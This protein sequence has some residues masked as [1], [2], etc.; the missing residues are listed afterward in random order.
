MFSKS[1]R[2]K[3]IEARALLD[4][5]NTNRTDTSDLCVWGIRF[6]QR[7]TGLLTSLGRAGQR[8]LVGETFCQLD[9]RLDCVYSLDPKNP[10]INDAD[11]SLFTSC[12]NHV[13]L[14]QTNSLDK[15]IYNLFNF[16]KLQT[17]SSCDQ[18]I[19]NWIH[20]RIFYRFWIHSSRWRFSHRLVP[21]RWSVERIDEVSVNEFSFNFWIQFLTSLK[22][23]PFWLKTVM[24][25]HRGICANARIAEEVI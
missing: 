7:D 25:S 18:R 10:F 14:Y 23:K 22:V 15:W 21:S 8:L 20:G 16:W 12:T 1:I 5:P 9:C 19:R 2:V 13:S 3:W 17:S 4:L 6:W 11:C 24:K